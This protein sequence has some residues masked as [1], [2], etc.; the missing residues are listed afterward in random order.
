[1]KGETWIVYSQNG[2]RDRAF[3]LEVDALEWSAYTGGVVIH[4]RPDWLD[5]P[6]PVE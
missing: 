1:M 3:S 5:K 4:Y 6:A 2:G